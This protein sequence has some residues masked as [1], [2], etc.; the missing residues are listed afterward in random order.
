MPFCFF[1]KQKYS[2]IGLEKSEVQ[3]AKEDARSGGRRNLFD[4]CP[5]EYATL[6][7]IIDELQFEQKPPYNEIYGLLNKVNDNSNGLNMFINALAV[8]ESYRH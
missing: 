6:M 4:R 1:F 2:F 3:C 8:T 7:D 5:V